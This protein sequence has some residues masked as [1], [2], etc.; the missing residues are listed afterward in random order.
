[1]VCSAHPTYSANRE[2]LKMNTITIGDNNVKS[3]KI[4][5]KNGL[6]LIAGPCVI[7]SRD[8]CFQIAE[9]LK[10]ITESLRIGYV[11]KASFDKANRTS[12]DSFR[13][14]GLEAGLRILEE[15]RR[16]FAVPV[17]SDIH[18]P[19]QAA[20][21]AR[22]LDCIQIPAFLCRQTDLLVAAAKTRKCI[23]V[24][25]A[26]FLAP[27]DMKHVIAKITA[28][29]NDNIILV[30]RGSSFGYNRLICDV[31]SIPQMQELGYPV[32]IDA[33]HST[34]QPGGLGNASGGAPEM[35]PVIARATVA[36]GADG[37]FLETHPHP[38]E[39]L[40]DAASMLPLD[41]IK[42]VMTVCRDIYQRIRE[43]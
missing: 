9:S 27:G 12:V 35:A 7:E 28:Q 30:E 25:K 13:G 21:A 15:L 20:P 10:T 8:L 4:G 17:V 32:V 26:Q 38:A 29:D 39:A 6:V 5:D 33:T 31:T 16:E 3:V 41:Q 40:S 18:L 22:V 2:L 24:K 11:F 14:P 43:S 36:A 1:M 23:Q 34:Q 37:V 42:D 19:D